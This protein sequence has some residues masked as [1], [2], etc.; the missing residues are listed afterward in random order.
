MAIGAWL[1]RGGISLM[2]ISNTNV[3]KAKRFLILFHP[4]SGSSWLRSMLAANINFHLGYE[5][6]ARVPAKDRQAEA[7]E[8]FYGQAFRPKVEAAGF[9]L[10]PYQVSNEIA[11]AD[12]LNRQET[13]I[14]D[15]R[16]RDVFR[17]GLSQIRRRELEA[18]A[19]TP[20]GKKM[21]NLTEGVEPPPPSIVDPAELKRMID[22]IERE[23]SRMDVYLARLSGPVHAVTYEDML[24]DHHRVLDGIA[25]F[26]SVEIAERDSFATRKN[27]PDDLHRAV[28]N[29]DEL[30]RALMGTKYARLLPE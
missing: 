19:R 25:D 11:V 4:R 20:E 14:I 8:S 12:A 27:T 21:A 7:I 9:K 28:A 15:V 26:L 24:A 22:D 13:R 1:E 10:A 2:A 29:Y 23:L 17:A 6:L 30:C 3:S 16:R 5:L 18:Y